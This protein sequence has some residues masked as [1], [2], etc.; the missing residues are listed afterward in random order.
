MTLK[1]SSRS[2]DWVDGVKYKI[3]DKW[4]LGPVSRSFVNQ[5]VS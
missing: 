4:H 5:P 1:Y 2:D 3:I